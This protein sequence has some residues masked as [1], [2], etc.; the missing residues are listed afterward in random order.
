[1]AIGFEYYFL[2][3]MATILCVLAPRIPHIKRRMESKDLNPK[4]SQVEDDQA[5][6]LLDS[7]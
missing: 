1:M 4:S 6:N 2:A 3:I 5:A 7:D